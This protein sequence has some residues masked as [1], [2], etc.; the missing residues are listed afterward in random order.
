MLG[1]NCPEC[2]RVAINGGGQRCQL[3]GCC[4]F[5]KAH[6]GPHGKHKCPT[7]DEL[8][9]R[10]KDCPTNHKKAHT[11]ET[12]EEKKKRKYHLLDKTSMI[13]THALFIVSNSILAIGTELKYAA[14]ERRQ[15][16]V[17][18]RLL[19][20]RTAREGKI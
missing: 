10:L 5:K 9:H 11:N 4:H 17:Q 1:F 13:P 12:D 3:T 7:P 16:I 8:E 14:P 6:V 18:H 15:A 19:E 2:C 20:L